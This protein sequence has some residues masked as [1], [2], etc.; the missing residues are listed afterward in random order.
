[1]CCVK[2]CY[3][4]SLLTRLSGGQVWWHQGLHE[5]V[6]EAAVALQ[7]TWPGQGG[8]AVQSSTVQGGGYPALGTTASGDAMI[9]VLG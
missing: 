7:H 5:V 4:T 3:T 8:S 1:M 9:G 6:A 2:R